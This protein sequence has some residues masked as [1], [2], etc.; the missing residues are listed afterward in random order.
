MRIF[1]T[2]FPAV[3][4][5]SVVQRPQGDPIT[6]PHAHKPTLQTMSLSTSNNTFDHRD[7]TRES[8][9][10]LVFTETLRPDVPQPDASFLERKTYLDQQ[11][12]SLRETQ[13][14]DGLTFLPGLQHRLHGGV[15]SLSDGVSSRE[16]G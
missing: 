16:G 13:V 14:L 8:Q 4:F 3:I 2:F 11:L 15:I 7:A 9:A 10:P 12:D 1:S 6:M 5:D